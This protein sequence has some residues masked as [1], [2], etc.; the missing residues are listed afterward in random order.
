MYGGVYDYGKE[1]ELQIQ[2]GSKLFP[3]YPMKSIAEQFSQL[4]K[5]LGIASSP[6]HSFHLDPAKYRTKNF[7]VGL[8]MERVLQAGYTGINTRAGDLLV[9]RAKPANNAAAFVDAV[10]PEKIFITLHSDQII[11]INAAG[12]AVLD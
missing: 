1:V 11:Q 10:N 8:D 4:R 7:I 3:E 5:C 9:A 12:V 2:I 6:V